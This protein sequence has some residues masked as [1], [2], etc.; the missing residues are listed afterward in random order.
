MVFPDTRG[1]SIN[2]KVI[3][4]WIF[5]ESLELGDIFF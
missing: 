1:K 4:L 3:E 2:K 5:R